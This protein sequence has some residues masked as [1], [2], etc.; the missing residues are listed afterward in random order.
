MEKL[1]KVM[2]DS[3]NTAVLPCPGLVGR[4]LLGITES[5]DGLI[6][7]LFE[8]GKKLVVASIPASSHVLEQRTNAISSPTEQQRGLRK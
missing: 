4:K 1:T 5:A 3:L 7:L 2:R 6:E 8:G